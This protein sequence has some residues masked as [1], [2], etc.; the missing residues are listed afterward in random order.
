[1]SNIITLSNHR[2]VN[3][4][5]ENT[6]VLGADSFEDVMFPVETRPIIV[7]GAEVETH[8]AIYRPDIDKTIVIVGKSYKLLHNSEIFGAFDDTLKNSGLDTDGMRRIV[9]LSNNGQRTYCRYQ[10]PA[11]SVSVGSKSDKTV[12]EF[13]AINSYDGSTSFTAFAGGYRLICSNGQVWGDHLSFFRGRHTA[14]LNIN[15][16]ADKFRIAAEKF[17][18]MG[19]EWEEWAKT[20]LTEVQ[21]FQIMTAAGMKEKFSQRIV[22]DFCAESLVL[23]K[24]KWSL[25]NCLTAHSSHEKMNKGAEA[26]APAIRQRREET[27]KKIITSQPWL[28]AA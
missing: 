22:E 7:E 1:M 19:D 28:Q 27:T 20:P 6:T 11:H 12:L 21:V 14:N 24:N 16:T 10:L 26:N 8:K 3:N 18:E 15:Q 17:N 13:C 25:F 5:A 9:D 23:G 4:A 2:N